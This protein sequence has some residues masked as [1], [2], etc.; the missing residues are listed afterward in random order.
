MT[1]GIVVGQLVLTNLNYEMESDILRKQGG[2]S[3]HWET[4]TPSAQVTDE[5]EVCTYVPPSDYENIRSSVALCLVS[6]V[7]LVEL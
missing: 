7:V 3:G 4:V 2:E 5:N 1:L 6:F